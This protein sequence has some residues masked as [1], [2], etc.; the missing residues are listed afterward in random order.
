MSAMS[1]EPLQRLVP[2]GVGARAIDLLRNTLD[3]N[4]DVR[5]TAE[6]ALEHDFFSDCPMLPSGYV[7]NDG[8]ST[9]SG[10]VDFR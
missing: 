1:G 10:E 3:M 2:S 6:Q 8:P 9:A 7:T 4:I 5:L